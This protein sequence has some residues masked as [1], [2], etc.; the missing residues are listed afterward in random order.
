MATAGQRA[1]DLHAAGGM[2]WEKIA[3][4]VGYT[5]GWGAQHAA[6]RAGY[7]P[8]RQVAA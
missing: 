6:K 1:A 5:S 2:S 8:G 3:Q 7:H 4:Q